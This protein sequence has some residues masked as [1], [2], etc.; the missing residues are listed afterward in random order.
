MPS[1]PQAKSRVVEIIEDVLRHPTAVFL[2]LV[3]VYSL[4]LALGILEPLDWW[5]NRT[6]R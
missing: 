1:R 5:G 6:G 2:A 4:A 3:A